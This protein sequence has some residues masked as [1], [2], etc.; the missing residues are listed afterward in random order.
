MK[1]NLLNFKEKRNFKGFFWE[2]KFKVKLKFQFTPKIKDLLKKTKW[3]VIYSK[4][5]KQI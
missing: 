3:K 5:I 1:T 4:N 2:T